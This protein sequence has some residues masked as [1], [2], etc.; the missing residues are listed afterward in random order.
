MTQSCRHAAFLVSFFMALGTQAFSGELTF[1]IATFNVQE[2]SWTK[3][4]E[5]DSRGRG[6]HPQL[7]AAAEVIQSVR[8]DVLLLNEIDYSGP[9]DSEGSP[10]QDRN[11]LMA[12]QSLYLAHSQ[13]GAESIDF[14]H[15]FYRPS[16]TGVPSGLDLNRDGKQ[17]GPADAFGYG[18][19]PGEY[20]LAIVSRHPLDQERSR[21]FRKLLWKDVPGHVMPDGQ[22]GR[23]S[24]FTPE[25]LAVFRL[26]SKSHWD[27]PV[28]LNGKTVH[29]LCSHPTPP[30]FDGPEDANGRRNFDELRFWSDYLTAGE[31][32]E[33][34]QDDAG[35]RGGLDPVESFVILGDLN[36]DP[37][38]SEAAYGRHAIE[39]VIGHPRVFDPQPQSAGGRSSRNA[40]HLDGFLPFK[41]NP[42][43]R[44]DY[45]LP[46]RDLN[47]AG[48]G[49]FWPGLGEPHRDIAESASDHRMVWIDLKID[50]E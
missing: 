35:L 16:N 39:W 11:A 40:E 10:P 4:R 41:T 3:L 17:N 46:S 48:S 32:A 43:G 27:V 22:E 44:L 25:S 21:T 13:N 47:V 12:F 6:T 36:A 9:V 50:A 5:V 30:I 26:S 31:R 23:P 29:L 24:F 33:W 34:I 37:V 42:F 19:Y 18:R 14:P 2:L 8:P 20:A 49:V 28:N 1:R 15:A 45:A 38:H 7:L